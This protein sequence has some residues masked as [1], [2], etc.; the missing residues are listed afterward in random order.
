MQK[1][2]FIFFCCTAITTACLSQQKLYEK[3]FAK[4]EK[5]YDAEQPSKK[6]DSIAA[7]LYLKAYADALSHND[8]NIVIECLN[9]TGTINQTYLRYDDALQHYRRAYDYNKQ[10]A[11]DRPLLYYTCLYMGTVFYQQGITDSAKH[12]FES[13]S[14]LTEAQKDY[15]FP[16]QERLFNSLGAIY[17]EIA[18]YQQA[19]N[20]FEKAKQFAQH[21]NET[22]ITLESNVANCLMQLNKVQDAIAVFKR[23]LSGRYIQ[24]AILYNLGHAYFKLD[25]YDS[26]KAYFSKVKQENDWISV[27]AK[28]DEARMFIAGKKFEQASLLLDSSLVIIDRLVPNSHNKDRALNY[29]SRSEML[30]ERGQLQQAVAW[31]DSALKEL[32]VDY[33]D[34]QSLPDDETRCVSPVILLQVLKTK[35]S[36]LEKIYVSNDDESTLSDCFNTCY[37]SI[38]VASYIRRWLDND[39]AKMFFQ[40]D[41]SD[42]YHDAIRIAYMLREKERSLV[43]AE[44]VIAIMD[45]YKGNV[46]YENIRLALAKKQSNVSADTQSKEKS[47]K[48]SLS[49]YTV[50]LGNASTNSQAKKIR[51]KIVDAQVEL[52]RLRQQLQDH[53]A[54]DFLKHDPETNNTYAKF[55]SLIDNQTAVLSFLTAGDMVYVVVVSK[56][57]FELKRISITNEFK[58]NYHRFIEEV[59]AHDEGK[60]YEGFKAGKAIYGSLIKPLEELVRQKRKWVIMPDGFLNYLPFD[61]LSVDDPKDFLVSNHVISYHYSMSLLM[62]HMQHQSKMHSENRI[63]FFAPFAKPDHLLQTASLPLL[64]F[65]MSEAPAENMVMFT[66]SQ[67]SKKE[68]LEQKEGA[69]IIHLATHATAGSASGAM[70]SFYPSDRSLENNNLYLDEIYALDLNNTSLVILSACETGAGRN[71]TGEGLLSLSRGFMYAGSKGMLSTLWKTEDEVSANLMKS[72]Y[73][74]MQEGYPAEEAL[75]RAKIKF[76]EDRSISE[77]YKTPN[78][79]SNFIYVGRINEEKP[80]KLTMY[81][82]IPAAL[83]FFMM[84]VIVIVR[85]R[86]L[87]SRTGV[88]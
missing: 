49:Y 16:E 86:Q 56:D 82:M 54:Y 2:L 59:Y 50:Q 37:K 81:L 58:A 40:Q 53:H 39:E 52:S 38:R 61:G 30:S 68:F 66:G 41:Q 85:K 14:A 73:K 20:Y 72:F 29:L 36:L 69:D 18:N 47:L 77:K 35:A 13:A 10:V 12:Y 27:R 17:F 6:S 45:E 26:A 74:E 15:P 4:A 3:T 1:V 79:W 25:Q 57:I 88:Q 87:I 32:Y 64:P 46:L 5:L 75:Q 65:S 33:R 67:A 21:D 51:Q 84:A 34:N 19:A 76:L 71:V 24:R 7:A 80:R 22:R 28:N 60:R 70:I 83:C 23:L 55:L 78:Y 11:N 42:I 9:K 63:M 31:T 48:E 43:S 44:K 62:Y 8:H